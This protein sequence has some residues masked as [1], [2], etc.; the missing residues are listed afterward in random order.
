MWKAF[1]LANRNELCIISKPIIIWNL[2]NYVVTSI[3]PKKEKKKSLTQNRKD[4]TLW[5]KYFYPEHIYTF[6]NHLLSWPSYPRAAWFTSSYSDY[7]KYYLL[8]KRWYD[9]AAI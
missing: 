8:H 6:S 3:K 5:K 2:T 7:S 1:F 4:L 9:D